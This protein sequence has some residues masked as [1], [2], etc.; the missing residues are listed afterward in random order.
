MSLRRDRDHRP[1]WLGLIVLAAI[2]FASGRWSGPTSEMAID[3]AR[4]AAPVPRAM[5]TPAARAA[6]NG[7]ALA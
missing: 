7:R 1:S 3:E 5:A 2:A 6:A 4:A